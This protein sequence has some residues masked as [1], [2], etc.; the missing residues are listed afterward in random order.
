MTKNDEVV[1]KFTNAIHKA[2]I[3]VQEHSPA[4]TASVISPYFKD[5]DHDIIESSVKRYLEQGSYAES[6]EF[7][8]ESWNNLLDVME[9]AG[10]LKERVSVDQLTNN[11]YAQSAKK[12]QQSP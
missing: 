4:E 2:Q 3:W 12:S 7:I 8:E 10:E 11:K 5:T 1:Q 9:G 6:P